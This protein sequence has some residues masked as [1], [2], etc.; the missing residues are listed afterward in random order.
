MGRLLVMNTAVSSWFL[1]LLAGGAWMGPAPEILPSVQAAPT[2]GAAKAPSVRLAA[3]DDDARHLVRALGS[4]RGQRSGGTTSTW[5]DFELEA[6]VARDFDGDG[7]VDLA[8]ILLQRPDE[9]LEQS[10]QDRIVVMGLRDAAGFHAVQQS[11]CLSLATDEGGM[12]GDPGGQMI[13]NDR[14][15]V[16][17]GNDG[18]SAWRWSLAYTVAWRHTAFRVVGVDTSAF[19]I[20]EP[21]SEEDVSINLLTGNYIRNRRGPARPHPHTA[22]LIGDCDA[23][24]ALQSRTWL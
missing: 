18:G 22:P 13:A 7:V 1:W 9:E 2:Q 6:S 19:Y 4:P 14:G 8:L 10:S 20:H 17:F 16:V 23:L 15:G 21:G 12:M 24:R 11:G 5:E 3:F